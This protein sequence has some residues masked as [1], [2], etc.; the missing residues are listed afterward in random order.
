MALLLR[1]HMQICIFVRS[2][3]LYI[4]ILIILYR[5]DIVCISLSKDYA[6]RSD[7]A[8]LPIVPVSSRR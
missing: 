1:N 6:L 8:P 7:G 3:L 5:D 4:Y 2:E